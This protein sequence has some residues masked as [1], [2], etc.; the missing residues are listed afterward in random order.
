MIRQ[1][2]DRPRTR[3][4][5]L[6]MARR[7]TTDVDQ[8][9]MRTMDFLRLWANFHFPRLLRAIDRIQRDVFARLASARTPGNYE[10]FAAQLENYFFDPALVALDEYGIPLEIARQIEFDLQPDGDLDAV[11]DRLRRLDVSTLRLTAFERTMVRHTQD[12]L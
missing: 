10:Y 7:A 8:F 4:L 9:V 6:I 11:L 3:D 5:I 2:Y 12:S 1:L